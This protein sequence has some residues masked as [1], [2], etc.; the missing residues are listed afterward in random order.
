M[1]TAILTASTLVVKILGLLFSI[2]L[3]NFISQAGMSYFYTA[4]DIFGIFLTLSTAGLPLAVSRMVGEAYSRKEEREA[5]RVF[6]ISFWLF[7]IL[8]LTGSIFMFCFSPQLARFMGNPNAS[9]AIRALSPTLFFL[10]VMSAIRGYFQGRSNMVPTAVS[11]TI[12]AVSK[13]VIGVGLAITIINVYHNDSWAA[14]G[15][16]I[17]VSVSAGLGMLY[18]SICKIK[19]SR[20]DRLARGETHRRRR[21]WEPKHMRG[22]PVPQA[23]SY[24]EKPS[25]AEDRALLLRLIRFS[26]PITIGACFLNLLDTAD[27]AVLMERLQDAAGFTLSHAEDLRGI[28]GHARKFFDLPGAFVVPISTSLLPALSGALAAGEKENAERISGMSMRVSLLVSFPATVGMCIFS[29]PVCD[30]LLFHV[31]ETAAATSPLLATLSIAIVANAVLMTTNAILQSYGHPVLP[32]ANMA[33][34]GVVKIILSYILTG[35]PEINVMGSAISTLVSY[36]L[37]AGLNLLA[38]SKLASGLKEA[39]RTLPSVLLST[40]LMG[41]LSYAVYYGLSLLTSSRLIILP[42]ILFAVIVYVIFSVKT[43]AVNR[44]L[45]EML[46]RGEKLV[47]LLRLND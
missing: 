40:A 19:Q 27:A 15:A 26:V 8:G 12:E 2:P 42:V 16:I 45:L 30:L 36:F 4:Y 33:V 17:G 43:G 18:L 46:P 34:G 32:V 29:E 11:Q 28:L 35:I 6:S 41:V 3:A 10:S 22:M 9:S 44:E 24:Y 39:L 1:G 25:A 5:D 23:A 14:T 20:E 37:M 47:K 31:P 38:V 21:G 7:F 13:V